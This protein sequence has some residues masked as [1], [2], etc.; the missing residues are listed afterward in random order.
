MSKFKLPVKSISLI[1]TIFIFAAINFGQEI[2][3]K[4]QLTGNVLKFNSKE[5]KL[6]YE[7][8]NNSGDNIFITINPTQ[9]NGRK[10]YYLS[11]DTDN[12]SRIKISS[13]AYTRPFY[14]E[15]Y[16]DNCSVELKKLAAGEK[17]N[18][19]ISIKFPAK[20]SDP[21]YSRPIKEEKITSKKI[22]EIGLT[23][24]YFVEEEGIVEFLTRKPFGWYISG[25]TKLEIGK[26]K[27]KSF[28]ELQNLVSFRIQVK[29]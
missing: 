7:I 11:M 16:A 23:I 3:S 5:L 29:E 9:V 2:D 17:Y 27:G 15:S 10:E 6:K 12:L 22:K 24:G 26:N 4:I 21:P 20:E 13:R 28:L 14:F 1:L 19:I 25:G 18:E 8:A